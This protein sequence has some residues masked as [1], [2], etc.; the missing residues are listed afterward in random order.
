MTFAL[1]NNTITHEILQQQPQPSNEPLFL[2]YLQL[3]WDL[4]RIRE[5]KARC[6]GRCVGAFAIHVFVRGLCREVHRK[7]T[8][9]G[10]L[11]YLFK[12]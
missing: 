12:S 11:H 6:N 5:P 9:A 7:A 2:M 1:F 4:R 10:V 3:F 8:A